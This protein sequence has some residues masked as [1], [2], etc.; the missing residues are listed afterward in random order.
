MRE[1]LIYFFN[2]QKSAIEAH[3]F[4]VETYG[5]AALCERRYRECFKKFKEGEFDIEDKERSGRPKVSED[6][7]LQTLLDQGSC[8]TQEEQYDGEYFE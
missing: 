7:E 6:V 1:P 4:L 2:L 8:Q 3:R 5:K